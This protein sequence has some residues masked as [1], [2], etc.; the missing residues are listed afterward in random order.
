MWCDFALHDFY[1]FFLLWNTFIIKTPKDIIFHTTMHDDDWLPNS[2]SIWI[3]CT[4][5]KDVKRD[6]L[7]HAPPTVSVHFWMK[8]LLYYIQSFSKQTSHSLYFKLYKILLFYSIHTSNI[9]SNNNSNANNNSSKYYIL[10]TMVIC[11]YFHWAK[12][13]TDFSFSVSQSVHK[14]NNHFIVSVFKSLRQAA[15]YWVSAFQY[16]LMCQTE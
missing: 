10:E 12:P 3:Y 2:V 14:N 5:I 11:W 6:I 16:R 9:M 7:N 1:N 8:R 4:N 13:T 15:M